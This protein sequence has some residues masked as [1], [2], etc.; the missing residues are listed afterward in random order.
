VRDVRLR[1]SPIQSG[2]S[3]IALYPRSQSEIALYP[4]RERGVERGETTRERKGQGREEEKAG[5]G[6][7]EKEEG[8][9]GG[10]KDTG[11]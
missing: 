5:E 9:R 2:Q 6:E 1:D 8:R 11:E 4:R 7:E 3:E 10:G